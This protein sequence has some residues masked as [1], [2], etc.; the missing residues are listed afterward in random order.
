MHRAQPTV[1]EHRFRSFDGQQL[2]AKEKGPGEHAASGVVLCFPPCV[3]SHEFFDCDVPG[4]SLMDFLAAAGFRVLA[5]DPRG[6]ARSHR[7]ADGRSITQEI[8]LRDGE[9][10][11]EF[12]LARTGATTVSMVGYGSGTVVACNLASLHP[13]PVSALALMDFV[14]LHSQAAHSPPGVQEML[15]A[16]PDGYVQLAELAGFFEGAL[17]L[18][19]PQV[20]AWNAATFRVAPVGPFLKVWS[21]PPYVHSPG[22]IRAAV[23][24][25]RG[26]EAGITSESDSLDFLGRI[27]GSVRTLDVIEGA[28]PVPSLEAPHH[29]RVLQDIAWFLG[30]ESPRSV[31]PRR[32]GELA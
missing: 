6:F 31:P 7:P 3:N 26:T 17:R 18:A 14:W 2:Y 13:G 23:L 1:R 32:P 30:R 5:Y 9:R 21:P 20:R 15:L 24:I 8:E 16:R 22:A 10:F 27:G 28:G 25:I 12:A 11:L 19:E 4:Y 29:R